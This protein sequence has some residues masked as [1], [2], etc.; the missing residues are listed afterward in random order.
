MKSLLLLLLTVPLITSLPNPS[1][2]CHSENEFSCGD[3]CIPIVFKCDNVKDCKSG[4][5]EQGCTY[6]HQCPT[7]DFMCRSGECITASFK[8][9]GEWDCSDGSDENGC[10]ELELLRAR[11]TL[12]L[13]SSIEP[14]TPKPQECDADSNFE[15][16][17]SRECLPLQKRCDGVTD[18]AYG[19]DEEGCIDRQCYLDEYVMCKDGVHCIHED[20]FC[21]GVANC[22]DGSDEK[23]CSFESLPDVETY[24]NPELC[25]SSEFRCSSGACIPKKDMCNGVKDCD[26]GS[27]EEGQCGECRDFGCSFKCIDSP[28]G[29]ECTCPPKSFLSSDYRTCETEDLCAFDVHECNQHCHESYGA[30]TCYCSEGYHLISPNECAAKPEF[31]NG[32]LFFV[33]QQ[34]SVRYTPLFDKSSFYEEQVAPINGSRILS[35]AFHPS[36][37]QLFMVVSY[38]QRITELVVHDGTTSSTLLTRVNMKHIAVD[39]ITGNIYYTVEGADPGIGVCSPQGEYCRMLIRGE[40]NDDNGY[41]QHYGGL[42][43]HPKR[44][45][46]IWLERNSEHQNGA[47]M[48]ADTDGQYPRRLDRLDIDHLKTISIDYVQDH[49]YVVG[50]NSLNRID[51]RTL[52]SAT[53]NADISPRSMVVFNG[54]YYYIEKNSYILKEARFGDEKARNLYLV[55]QK[56]VSLAINSRLYYD[57]YPN[58]C[59]SKKCSHICVL[60]Q[61]LPSKTPHA[62]CICPDQYEMV[63]GTCVFVAGK[64]NFF[65]YLQIF[66]SIR[67]FTICR[68]SIQFKLSNGY[69]YTKKDEWSHFMYM[70]SRYTRALKLSDVENTNKSIICGIKENRYAENVDVSGSSLKSIKVLASAI[71][72]LPLKK[73]TGD[74]DFFRNLKN[75]KIE[76]N[77][78]V[79]K[80]VGNC[81]CTDVLLLKNFLVSEVQ[82]YGRFLISTFVKKVRTAQKR[83][84]L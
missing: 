46:I 6:L 14:T 15:C 40:Y 72:S 12:E 74:I 59:E 63:D 28:R 47:V 75:I 77:L 58:P 38:K 34:N 68:D 20:R 11:K 27:D 23:S 2:T 16:K 32:S 48:V 56:D 25:S 21:D 49:L 53:V 9:N 69:E 17:V 41:T 84:K 55:G 54:Y 19:D 81:D 10:R 80:V 45:Q 18:C 82:I 67:T 73:F 43:F 76:F 42:I 64:E 78:N 31:H 62:K 66:Q 52:K 79:L 13:N 60:K 30:V 22:P 83:N 29:P 70:C 26:D 1:A 3:F 24:L 5:D 44:S 57:T 51:L 71:R 39:W 65:A 37:N 33:H 36:T 7:N 4:A 8:C 50:D 35:L 61:K